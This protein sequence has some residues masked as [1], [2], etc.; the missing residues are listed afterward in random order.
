MVAFELAKT[1]NKNK[2][3]QQQNKTKQKTNKQN[4]TKQKQ[5]QKKTGNRTQHTV[6]QWKIYLLLI[7]SGI[8]VSGNNNTSYND[9]NLYF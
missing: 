9:N 1:K 3:K 2:T 4:K 6:G 7:R 8:Q 5:K